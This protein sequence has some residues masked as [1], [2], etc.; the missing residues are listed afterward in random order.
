MVSGLLSFKGPY[1]ILNFA[2]F[3]FFLTFVVWFNY[4]PFA[5]TIRADF[6]L[7]LAQ[8]RT[9]GL[10]N[11]A[12][13]IPARILIGM[14]LDRLGPR[15]TYSA[16]LIYAAIPCLAFA[17]AQSFE[18]LV[19]SRLAMGIVGAG[20]VVGIRLVA[21]W[22]DAKVIGLAQGIYGGWGN[23]GSFASEAILPSIALA[24]AFLASGHENWRLAIALSGLVSLIF[25]VLFYINVRD[26][27]KDKQYIRPA[28]DGALELTSS[29]SFWAFILTNIPIFGA[30]GLIVWR[31]QLVKFLKPYSM[32]SLWVLLLIL[33]AFSIYQSYRVNYE[34]I[35]GK[36]IYPAKDRYQMGQIFLLE[37][38]YAV[39]FGSELAV[40][41][42]LPEFFEHTYNLSHA[43]SGLVAATFP[44][45]NIVGR[46]AGGL[47]SDRIGSRKNALT[48]MIA[49]VG[50]GYLLMSLIT[51]SFWLPLAIG[52]TMLTSF[53]VCGGSGATFGI[54]PLLKRSVTG[55]IAGNVGAYGS[56]GSV[57]YATLYSLLPQ[58][59]S[60]NK[61]FFE[62][63]GIAA[64]IVAF[65][66]LFFLKDTKT[67]SDMTEVENLA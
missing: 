19:I 16:I 59:I 24:T 34:V 65:L 5:T 63:L 50:I 53:F 3:A 17:L 7:T 56:V 22:F 13:T 67:H 1:K 41:S 18:Q 57:L 35:T 10:C 4:A 40:V 37:L 20:F 54:A 21:E 60:G 48:L 14:I 49:G 30:M 25:G 8:S 12:L 33:F 39:S 62:V 61:T 28:R 47:I 43:T 42:M 64:L 15:I 31:L 26:T 66:C 9:I 52:M 38:A 58:G 51:S 23:F 2:W 27:P 55:Q 44:L 29:N 36:K 11:L 45:M 6:H 32:Y 46:P